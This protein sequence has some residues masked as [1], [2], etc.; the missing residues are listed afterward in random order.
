MVG[1]LRDIHFKETDPT[2]FTMML[3]QGLYWI[4]QSLVLSIG[5]QLLNQ[6]LIGQA[7]AH[8]AG[9]GVLCGLDGRSGGTDAGRLHLWESLRQTEASP[10][11]LLN[12]VSSLT[13]NSLPLCWSCPHVTISTWPVSTVCI[14]LVC[15]WVQGPGYRV[16]G[17]MLGKVKSWKTDGMHR[18]T[19]THACTVIHTHPPT[20]F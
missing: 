15:H 11:Y 12:K 13:V 7:T 4:A 1:L 14:P 10:L 2:V 16:T 6:H 17:V 18:H 8:I 20:H 9:L 19:N 3:Y 5:F